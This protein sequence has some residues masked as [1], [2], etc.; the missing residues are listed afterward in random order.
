[1]KQTLIEKIISNKLGK[2]VYSGDTEFVP[3]DLVMATDGTAPL[4][5]KI[6]EKYNIKKVLN[7]EKIVFVNDHFV[8]APNISTANLAVL[9]EKFAKKYGISNYKIGRGGIC[10]ILLPE[11]NLIKPYDIVLGADSHTCTYGGLGAFSSG[12]GSTDLACVMATGKLWLRVPETIKINISG[13]FKKNVGPKDLILYIIKTLG[14]NGASYKA[15]EFHGNTLKDIDMSGRLTICNMVVECG[16]KAGIFNVD[17]ITKK[18]FEKAGFKN[19][20]QI[21]PDKDAVY[22]RTLDIDVSNLEPQIACPYS[23]TNVIN[24]SDLIGTKIDQVVLGSCTNGRIEDFR[25][26]YKYLKGR[27]VHND[28]KLIIIPGSQKVLKQI[29]EEGMLDD[30]INSNAVI[31]PPTC[32]PCMGGHMGVLGKGE[33]GLYTTNRNFYGRNGDPTSKVYLC[34]PIIAVYSALEGSIQ[35]PNF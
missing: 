27:K 15:I 13:K 1:M 33:I 5:L 18:H 6:F 12:I 25:M 16:A 28:V 34:N 31:A 10:H 35:I 19:I 3:I 26:A 7:P 32:G 17:D 11:L 30:F 2:N 14:E 23:P 4:A 22:E 29:E 9:I 24:A 20:Q 8:P 21:F